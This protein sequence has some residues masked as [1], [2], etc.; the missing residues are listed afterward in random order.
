MGIVTDPSCSF[1][2]L[3]FLGDV[4][5]NMCTNMNFLE[6]IKGKVP[7][8]SKLNKNISLTLFCICDA[9]SGNLSFSI[10]NQNV[11]E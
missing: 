5:C 3:P 10:V 4:I 11:L 1:P 7:Q 9:L 6:L 8:V 2:L